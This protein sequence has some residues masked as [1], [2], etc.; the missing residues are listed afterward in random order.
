MKHIAWIARVAML[1]L[2]LGGCSGTFQVG[3][4]GEAAGGDPDA[5]EAMVDRWFELAGSGEDDFGWW[6]VHPNTRTDLIGSIDVYR[7]A[8]SWV[9]WPGFSYEVVVGRLH[10]GEYDIDVQVT[11]GQASVPEPLCRWGLIQFGTIDGQPSA[12]GSM[13]VRIAPFGEESGILGVG[14]GC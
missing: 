3:D 1:A 13:T 14:G 2:V 12:I 6:L 11:G 9:D 5:A 8:M 4:L 10:D 7:E